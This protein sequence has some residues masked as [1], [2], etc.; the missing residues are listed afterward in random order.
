[1]GLA[2]V[3][4]DYSLRCYVNSNG[5]SV[6]NMNSG[7]EYGGVFVFDD[8]NDLKSFKVIIES[9]IKKMEDE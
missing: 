7:D 9:V 2:I 4:E 1:M 5:Y 8:I 3:N 6:I